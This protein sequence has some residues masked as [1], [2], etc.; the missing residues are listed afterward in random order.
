MEGCPSRRRSLSR[1]FGRALIC[2]LLGAATLGSGCGPAAKQTGDRRIPAADAEWTWLEKTRKTL[3]EQRARLAV[4]D[5]TPTPASTATREAL[6]KQ[7]AALA[8]ELDRR[9]VAFINADPPVQGQSLTE[10]QKTALRMK[11]DEDVVLARQL[12]DEGGDYQRAIA[13]YEEDLAVDPGDPQLESELAK[14]QARRYMAREIFA[15]LQKGMSQDEVRGL[16]GAPNPHS[17][18]EYP[19]RGVVGW[20]YPKNASGTAA[21][22]WFAKNDGRYAVYLFDFDAIK[23]PAAAPPTLPR[24]SP[25]HS[26]T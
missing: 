19:D 8:G 26:A 24:P 23:P 7:T 10:R 22:V 5:P 17:V 25:A 2:A 21:A 13:I 4:A 18:R 16:L 6:R 1:H 3:E 20:F 15:Q 11:S 14:A 9:L 12:I